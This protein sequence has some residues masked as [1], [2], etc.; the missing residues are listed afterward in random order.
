M[1]LG[2]CRCLPKPL[3]NSVSRRRSVASCRQLSLLLSHLTGC[4]EMRRRVHIVRPQ[5]EITIREAGVSQGRQRL[6]GVS[7][8]YARLLLHF[9]TARQG[10]INVNATITA[11]QPGS[12]CS[13]WRAKGRPLLSSRRSDSAQTT[14]GPRVE[15]A[16]TNRGPR[17]RYFQTA[18]HRSRIVLGGILIEAT[19]FPFEAT[20]FPSRR[21]TKSFLSISTFDGMSSH[22]YCAPAVSQVAESG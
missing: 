4:C 13:G 20:A 7:F 3:L 11:P 1:V 2:S 8:R 12:A 16:T 18:L 9:A 15:T 19:A 17:K 5:P 14:T 6:P 21:P 10:R 22:E